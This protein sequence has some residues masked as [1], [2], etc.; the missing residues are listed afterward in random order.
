MD[1]FRTLAPHQQF[2]AQGGNF[3]PPSLGF[4]F[5]GPPSYNHYRQHYSSVLHQQ[6]GRDLFTHPVTSSMDLF[7]FSTNS[8]HSHKGQIHSWLPERDSGPS[9]STKSSH[10]NRVASPPRNS[11]PDLRDMG[12]SNSGHVCQSPQH[13]SSPVYVSNSRA[14]STGDR[15]SVTRL[16]GEVDVHVSTI[17]PAQQS[18]SETTDHP[19]GQSDTNSPLVAV[20]TMVSTSNMSVCG[21]LS[22][23][24]VLPGSTVTTGV[25]LGC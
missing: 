22:H 15:C 20:T 5:T 18:H 3:G 9:I 19:G 10:N 24:S 17:S 6:T 7:L 25:C 21:P 8:G 1:P 14:S 2:E 23:Q 13:A 11:E 16:A 4:N 12:N